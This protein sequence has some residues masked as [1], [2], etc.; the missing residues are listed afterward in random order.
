MSSESGADIRLLMRVPAFGGI[1]RKTASAIA[2]KTQHRRVSRGTRLIAA[3]EKADTLYIVLRGRFTVIGKGG[4]IAEIPAGEP[5]GELA[6]FAGG[7]RTADVVAARDS[8]VLCLSKRA[9]RELAASIPGLSES[10]L[11]SVAGRLARNTQTSRKLRPRTGRIVGLFAGGSARLPSALISGLGE[12]LKRSAPGKWQFVTSADAPPGTRSQAAFATW[13]DELESASTRVEGSRIMLIIDDSEAD[14]PFTR[15]ASAHCDTAILAMPLGAEKR[16]HAPSALEERILATTQPANIHLVFWREAKDDPIRGAAA[17]LEHRGNCLHHHLGL[18]SRDDFERLARF[19]E[20]TAFGAVFCGGGAFGTAHLGAVKALKEAGHNIDMLGGTSVGAAMAGALAMGLEPDRI[21]DLCDEMFVTS[22]AMGKLNI[23]LYS[24][25]DHR[26]FDAQMQK[27]YGAWKV[28]DL[29]THFFSVTTSL[30]YNDI[31]V[32]RS[33]DLWRAVRASSSIPAVFPP[34]L[35]EDG[36]VMIDGALI[37][38]VPIGVMRDIKRG[39]NLILNFRQREP[40]LVKAD[41]HQ[42]PTRFALLA[43]IVRGKRGRKQR[44]PSIFSILSR[45]MVVNSR[46][47][48]RELP[49]EDDILLEIPALKGMGFLEWRR[50]RRQF[51]VAYRAMAEALEEADKAGLDP[52]S[53][54]RTASAQL[55]RPAEGAD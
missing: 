40:W 38:N 14:H 29:P 23:P 47:L 8:E 33:G 36:E 6:F 32:I 16:D 25:I 45:T 18:D 10:I 52:I 53:Q 17:L 49:M 5:V 50:G 51:E 22:K 3:G 4:P 13:L 21:M 2:A 55:S 7:E 11:A 46:K 9:W 27:H 37:D 35:G 43:R 20:G 12:A 28:E 39:S 30:T 19:L 1:S 44:F 15:A 54:L 34:L 24:V 42:L 26:R 31:K 41:Y 48:L